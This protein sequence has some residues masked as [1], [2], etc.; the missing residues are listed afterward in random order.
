MRLPKRRKS[1]IVECQ[2]LGLTMREHGGHNV[3]IM[4]LAAAEF[5]NYGLSSINSAHTAGPSSRIRKRRLK[6]VGVGSR[7]GKVKRG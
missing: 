2:Q 1:S 3:R 4:H 7:I 6:R 5:E